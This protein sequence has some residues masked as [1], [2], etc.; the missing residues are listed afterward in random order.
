MYQ[1]I[2]VDN[3]VN[4]NRVE[5]PEHVKTDRAYKTNIN[6][7]L[8]AYNEIINTVNTTPLAEVIM[9]HKA[10]DVCT[11]R[12]VEEPYDVKILEVKQKNIKKLRIREG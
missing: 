6:K 12:R 2:F 8:E 11:V 3:A 5:I 7:F 10:G 4:I 1:K 9:D